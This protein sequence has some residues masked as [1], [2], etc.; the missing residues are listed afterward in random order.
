MA[1]KKTKFLKN[2]LT[3]ASALAVIAGGVENAM[4]NE[5]TVAATPAVIDNGANMGAAFND[6]D[7]IKVGINNAAI[8]AGAG[9]RVAGFDLNDKT[10][11]TL[12]VDFDLSLGAVSPNGA[13]VVQVAG[14]TL[15][16]T[17]T[18][19][20]VL[21]LTGK[22]TNST[23]GVVA[24]NYAGLGP[25]IL[26][27][28]AAGTAKVVIN[29]A[30]GS[31]IFFNTFDGNGDGRGILEIA[32]GKEAEFRG[33][34]G[35]AG[36]ATKLAEIKLAGAAS[37]ATFKANVKATAINLHAADAEM[38]I[39]NGAEITAGIHASN[40]NHEGI[41]KFVGNGKITGNLGDNG[42]ANLALVEITNAATDA[43][44][45]GN[46]DSDTLK[47]TG[48]ASKLT[49]KGGAP[50]VLTLAVNGVTANAAGDGTLVFEGA[51]K[52]S[53]NVG[54]ANANAIGK[55]IIGDGEVELDGT[56]LKTASGVELS[57]NN[58]VLKLSANATVVTSNIKNTVAGANGKGK[59]L[60][61]G[62]VAVTIAG[63]V[64]EDTA[65]GA[66]HDIEINDAGATLNLFKD[67]AGVPP[68]PDIII[69]TTNGIN[70]TGGVNGGI[71]NIKSDGMTLK[72]NLGSD[73]NKLNEFN[74]VESVAGAAAKVTLAEN[75]TVVATNVKLG[76][77]QIATLV[78]KE[79]SHVKTPGGALKLSNAA[80]KIIFDGE[81]AKVT[82]NIASDGGANRGIVEVND[83][84]MVDG[85]IG[86]AVLPV[87]EIKFTAA[88]KE[89]TV[90]GAVIATNAGIKFDNHGTLK[91]TKATNDLKVASA[92]VIANDPNGKGEI[93][94]NTFG[95]GDATKVFEI[96]GKVGDTTV[97]GGNIQALRLLEATGGGIVKLTAVQSHIKEV[98]LGGGNTKLQVHGDGDYRIEKINVTGGT[99]ELFFSAAGNN[100]K[101]L[102]SADAAA[103]YKLGTADNR[104]DVL[105]LGTTSQTRT[106]ENNINIYT[107]KLQ[108]GGDGFTELVFE[109]NALLATSNVNPGAD[110]K[111]NNALGSIKANGIAD[112][113]LQLSGKLKLAVGGGGKDGKLTI[114][115]GTVTMDSDFQ[116]VGIVANAPNAGKL[117]FVNPA[118]ITVTSPVDNNLAEVEFAGQN[119]TFVGN[120]QHGNDIKFSSAEEIIVSFDNLTNIGN[121]TIIN[122]SQG[123]TQTVKIAA[124]TVFTKA[125]GVDNPVNIE[126][127]GVILATVA[128]L[129]NET[130]AQAN[131]GFTTTT[132]GQGEVR[133]NKENAKIK[134]VGKLNAALAKLNFTENG[135]VSNN[136]YATNIEVANDKSAT[137][138][139]VIKGS[140]LKLMDENAE[141]IFKDGASVEIDIASEAGNNKGY[142]TFQGSTVVKNKLGADNTR[143]KYVEFANGANFVTELRQS[144]YAETITFGAGNVNVSTPV[145]L[146][147][148]TTFTSSI[149]NLGTNTAQSAGGS[150]TLTGAPK[151][152]TSITQNSAKELVGGK[153]VVDSTSA[154]SYAGLT[155]LVV[156]IVGSTLPTVDNRSFNLLDNTAGTDVVAANKLNLNNLELV[157]SKES[158]STWTKGLDAKGGI[159]LTLENN[160]VGGITESFKAAGVTLAAEDAT[161]LALIAKG[162]A[163][164]EQFVAALD[165]MDRAH[166]VEALQRISEAG[167]PE[168][169]GVVEDVV[170]TVSNTV[171]QR[172]VF[173]TA[174]VPL[175]DAMKVS[176]ADQPSGVGAGDDDARYGIWAN[177]FFGKGTQKA[178][179]GASGY[180]SDKFGASFGFDT[181]VNDDMVVGAALS[182]VDSKVKHK[183]K[184]RGDT[185]K[186]SSNL[187]SIYGLQQFT[188]NWFGQG[189]VTVGSNSVSNNEGRVLNN[190]TMQTAKGKYNSMSFSGEVMAGY[191]YAVEQV[192][193]TPMAGLRFTRVNDGGYKETGTTFQNFDI[194]KKASN[195]FELIAGARLSSDAVRIDLNDVS[196]VPELHGFV[197]YDTIAKN[198]Q[199]SVRM[200]GVSSP[201][202]TKSAKPQRASYNVGIGANIRYGKMEYSAGYD[203]NFSEKYVGH[204]GSVRVRVNF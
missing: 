82:G 166:R 23:G 157:F 85:D 95:A 22:N 89:F 197:N 21:T 149:I 194:S 204:E 176:S 187:L 79:N 71:V 11:T 40:G 171:S 55:L 132:P 65:T 37:K 36:G 201:L 203:A 116:A 151:I 90:T 156:E 92:V 169:T 27:T 199:V 14:K 138:G 124:N 183:D 118:A 136:V 68:N 30:V 164:A 18:D 115:A 83:D 19:G 42:V 72:T 15:G 2:L 33:A 142:A 3:T 146:N 6:D 193:I 150:L 125:I 7:A 28:A 74:I 188:D 81:G 126:L 69:Y 60:V 34:I 84:G 61:D 200:S 112:K 130:T 175:G 143:L 186:I 12:A 44:I 16:V 17:V 167:A 58:S 98:N 158:L 122:S 191:N 137:F 62:A 111:Y 9:H 170:S 45:T 134:F 53:G 165:K 99:G 64:G 179:K 56:V 127:N 76:N 78:L 190:T 147:G 5:R 159:V 162:T 104:I 173:P 182:H 91:L 101:L 144:V 96:T 41:V 184:K 31:S 120:F 155:K 1:N 86:T 48:A 100:T 77:A 141:A 181:K 35:S 163:D 105:N 57:H 110:A 172:M 161:N 123:K 198:P 113:T 202:A 174:T 75:Q 94:A 59:I 180:K 133:M 13:T 135:E 178:R 152:T 50:R 25:V 49:I 189:I 93:I 153:I 148:N 129:A 32:V 154:L 140:K 168:A 128:P 63:N 139:G 26:G 106:I 38:D 177:P 196:I 103:P 66:I 46:I 80:S 29:N 54:N 87:S 145:T 117:K 73:V 67:K 97:G 119:V 24:N 88:D 51:A 20:K 70:F 192:M 39:D 131:V 114:G 108:A 43:Q 47:F 52:I 107:N 10:G 4:A 8:S 102:G 109:G 195:K 160:V 121:N 185:T